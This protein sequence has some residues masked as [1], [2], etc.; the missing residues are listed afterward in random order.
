MN[1]YN[2]LGRTSAA[3]GRDWGLLTLADASADFELLGLFFSPLS[4]WSL[5]ALPSSS[6][7]LSSHPEESPGMAPWCPLPFCRL[8]QQTVLEILQFRGIC[9]CKNLVNCGMESLM[10]LVQRSLLA[11][12]QSSLFWLYPHLWD[13]QFHHTSSAMGTWGFQCYLSWLSQFL[14]HG[15]SAFTLGTCEWASLF[16]LFRASVWQMLEHLSLPA[17]LS[18]LQGAALQAISLGSLC[19]ILLQDLSCCPVLPLVLQQKLPVLSSA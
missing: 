1:L 9:S 5:G 6:L 2:F 11:L 7:L 15:P 13:A 16:P 3:L 14:L 19:S 10:L 8:P 12:L 4:I 18:L 17:R